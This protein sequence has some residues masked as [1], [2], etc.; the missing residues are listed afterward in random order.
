MILGY[1]IFIYTLKYKQ[2]NYR[3]CA[4]NN[5]TAVHI[6][7]HKGKNLTFSEKSKIRLKKGDKDRKWQK[8]TKT[9]KK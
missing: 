8:C 4:R 3:K 5:S 6:L 1:S 7:E 9:Y 2:L